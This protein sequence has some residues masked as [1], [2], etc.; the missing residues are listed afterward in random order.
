MD[1]GC[2]HTMRERTAMNTRITRTAKSVGSAT[3]SSS[4]KRKTRKL[5]PSMTS[6]CDK[7]ARIWLERIVTRYCPAHTRVAASLESKN[8]YL[9]SSKNAW[10]RHAK[11]QWMPATQM[12]KV[13]SL[14]TPTRTHTARFA[15]SRLW[16]PNLALNW[17]AGTFSMS[18]ALRQSFKLSGH[19]PE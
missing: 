10:T 17:V 13:Y 12:T 11:Y 5:V 14:R 3:K 19:H 8:A 9:A 15:G 18:S 1:A 16:A 4:T 2:S 6:V 7:S